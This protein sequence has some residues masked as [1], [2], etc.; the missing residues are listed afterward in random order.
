M[1][2]I[3]FGLDDQEIDKNAVYEAAGLAQISSFIEGELEE[4]Y[5]T[6][7]GEHGIRLS[8][9]QRQRL[10]IARALYHNPAVIILD[11]ATSSLDGITEQSFMRAVRDLAQKRT[12][13]IIAHRLA[14]LKN[15]D[16]IYMLE[17]GKVADRG[18]YDELIIKN[19]QF[20]GMANED[21][22]KKE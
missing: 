7:I 15:C 8:G 5:D 12:V 20:A 16:V 9:G 13:I 2:N 10:G 19:E 4:K 22:T 18:S 1:R 17:E 21:F 3:A 6:I 14:T 11:E